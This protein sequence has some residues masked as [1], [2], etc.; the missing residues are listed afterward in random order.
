MGLHRL[1]VVFVVD[2]TS[3]KYIVIGRIIQ[4]YSILKFFV[5]AFLYSTPRHIHRQRIVI[6]TVI[7]PGLI[8]YF[9]FVA[10]RG[11]VLTNAFGCIIDF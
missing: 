3:V 7:S 2:S 9:V 6:F 8:L 5:F 10:H 1:V 11:N 4:I